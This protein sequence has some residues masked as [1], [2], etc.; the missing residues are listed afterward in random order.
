MSLPPPP[1]PTNQPAPGG[2]PA[3]QPNAMPPAPPAQ[4]PAPQPAQPPA[5]QPAPSAQPPAPQ[6]ASPFAPPAQQ[7]ASPFAPPAAPAQPAPT[8]SIPAPAQPV[9]PGFGAQTAPQPGATQP[10]VGYMSQIPGAAPGQ[11]GV[12][13]AVPKQ[14]GDFAKALQ[15][16]LPTFKR[17]HQSQGDQAVLE[18]QQLKAWWWVMFLLFSLLSGLAFSVFVARS[19]DISVGSIINSFSNSFGYGSVSPYSILSFGYWFLLFFVYTLAT[20]IAVILRALFVKATVATAKG[21]L[22]FTQAANVV[23]TGL[24]LPAFATAAIFIVE[25]LPIPVLTPL[26]VIVLLTMFCYSLF[27]ME[28]LIN[29]AM[30]SVAKIEKTT[31]LSHTLFLYLWSVCLGILFVILISPATWKALTDSFSSSIGDIN[32]GLFSNFL[33]NMG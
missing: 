22:S 24:V 4:P 10:M 32:N 6:P 30:R 9:Q 18:N 5:A 8:G 27:M 7:P 13:M 28:L 1:E 20:F 19:A 2:A 21:S 26:L 25:L 33:H 17:M 14:N 3:P 29:T 31:V 15:A 16:I 12:Y 23:A 11:G